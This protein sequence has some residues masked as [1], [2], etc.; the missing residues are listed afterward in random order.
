MKNSEYG[1]PWEVTSEVSTR[2]NPFGNYSIN[3]HT[4]GEVVII[5]FTP[6][7]TGGYYFMVDPTV[8]EYANSATQAS[9]IASARLL[10]WQNV[11][12][13]VRPL[14][15]SVRTAGF[16]AAII[17][18]IVGAAYTVLST[19]QKEHNKIPFEFSSNLE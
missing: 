3:G 6:Q 8:A 11:T 4:R 13:L 5:Q 10:L 19:K 16:V 9:G 14:D 7:E 2:S 15:P 17:F 12:E 1:V 18:I